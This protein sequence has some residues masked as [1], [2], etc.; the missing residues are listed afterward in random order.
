M[1]TKTS[2]QELPLRER[3]K[4]LLRLSILE[5]AGRLFESRGYDQVTVTEIADAANISVK[6]LF[7]YFRGKDELVFHDTALIDAV[8]AALARRGAATPA[9]AVAGA[10]RTLVHDGGGLLAGLEGF[11]RGYGDSEALRLK[12]LKLWADYEE[13]VALALA[14]ETAGGRPGPELRLLAVQLIGLVRS[15]TWPEVRALVAAPPPGRTPEQAFE[16]WLA[17]AAAAI[18]GQFLLTSVTGT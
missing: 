6:T 12:I 1:T 18:D 13:R 5:H 2:I 14:A 9:Q 3:K 8:L 10:L 17:R 7:S 15:A 11:Q 16:D 4:E